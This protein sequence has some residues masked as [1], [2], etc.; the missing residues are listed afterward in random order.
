[1][2]HAVKVK[3]MPPPHELIR[4]NEPG[5]DTGGS[6]FG[7][8]SRTGNMI[9]T[10][11][12]YGI[13]PVVVKRGSNFVTVVRKK[14]TVYKIA[15]DA[16]PFEYLESTARPIK[17]PLDNNW[18]TGKNADSGVLNKKT[19]K[20]RKNWTDTKGGAIQAY[21]PFKNRKNIIP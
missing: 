12:N 10:P 11:R 19:G 17:A 7:I 20:I 13:Q 14:K 2:N 3:K 15:D 5:M 18:K 6:Y 16:Q 1:M 4:F 8:S 9:N 21:I